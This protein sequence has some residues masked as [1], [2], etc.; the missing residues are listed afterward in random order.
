MGLVFTRAVYLSHIVTHS[1]HW[2]MLSQKVNV[3][4]PLT[5]FPREKRKCLAFF[6]A[7]NLS[8]LI[9]QKLTFKNKFTLKGVCVWGGGPVSTRFL[10][11]YSI[12]GIIRLALNTI[13]TLAFV[14]KVK[15]HFQ[16]VIAK[17]N[18]TD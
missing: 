14:T 7:N 10:V 13:Y 4:V 3:C 6:V 12:I 2:D 18:L 5:F 17:L 15:I 8:Y 9:I 11:A 16:I 1:Q